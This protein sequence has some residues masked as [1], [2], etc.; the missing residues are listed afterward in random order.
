MMAV[1]R[2]ARGCIG[3]SML[4]ILRRVKGFGAVGRCG[5]GGVVELGDLDLVGAMR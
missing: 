3:V 5:V 4:V 1:K 2:V